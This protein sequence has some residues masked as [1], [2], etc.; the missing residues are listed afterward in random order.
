MG[1]NPACSV[2]EIHDGEYLWQWSRLEIRLNGFRRS[3]NHTTKTIHHHF[4]LNYLS[5][6]TLSYRNI[7][8]ATYQ[9]FK[10][11]FK[12]RGSCFLAPPHHFHTNATY[13]TKPQTWKPNYDDTMQRAWI[14][15]LTCLYLRFK[16]SSNV[17]LLMLPS[18][19]CHATFQLC[20]FC[21][22]SW[23]KILMFYKEFDIFEGFTA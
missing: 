12:H 4:M 15:L 23:V 1:S 8:Q 18:F 13:I 21:F 20:L 17:N 10:L 9:L 7:K 19:F 16:I 5:A 22:Y 14:R 3:T 11:Q 6:I 2:L